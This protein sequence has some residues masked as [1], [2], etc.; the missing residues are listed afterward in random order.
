[1]SDSTL[2]DLYQP[3][4]I[5][6]PEEHLRSAIHINGGDLRSEL[7]RLPSDLAHYGFSFAAAHRRMLSAKMNHEEVKAAVRL[8]VRETRTDLGQKVT[9]DTVEAETICD[10]RVH[11]AR[12]SLIEAEYDRERLRAVVDA[13]RAKRE[14]LTS[15]VLLARA[16][17]AGSS[18]FREPKAEDH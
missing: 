10:G 14:N 1:M 13:L 4:E 7:E 18:G 3:T 11:G 16:E 15:L 12:V 9:E 8:E 6:D 17:L 2:D 5:A